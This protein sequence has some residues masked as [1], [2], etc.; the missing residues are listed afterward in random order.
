MLSLAFALTVVACG[1]SQGEQSTTPEPADEEMQAAP[2]DD[3]G[4]VLIP[5]E[6]FTEIQSTFQ[7]KEPI[8]ARCYAAAIEAGELEKNAKGYFTVG[9]T[10]TP[11]GSPTQIKVLETN[12]E[13]SSLES[14]VLGHVKTWKLAT[15]P[16]SLEYSYT[17]QFERF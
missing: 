1:G 8:V 10:I 3:G 12:L 13:S 16:R 14:C 17:Y 11:D 6:K 2:A 7:R 9:L 4:D 5:E 15:L